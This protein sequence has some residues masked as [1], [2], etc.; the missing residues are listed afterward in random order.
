M[1]KSIK[2]ISLFWVLIMCFS[3]ILSSCNSDS[4]NGAKESDNKST[5]K[6]NTA[7]SLIEEGKYEEA[8][9]TLAELGDY[10]DAAKMLEKFRYVPIK[11]IKEETNG[12]L[13]NNTVIT[14]FYNEQ[15]LPKQLIFED[16]DGNRSIRDYIYNDKGN[17]IK[18]IYTNYSG[19]TEIVEYTYDNKENLIKKVHNDSD[20]GKD[21]YDYI[22][23][24]KGNLTKEVFNS[25]NQIIDYIYDYNG[26]LLKE[27]CTYS[28][29][30]KSIFDYT[31][32][33][34]GILIKVVSTDHSG[35]K[36]IYDYTY[37]NNG[38]LSK[39]VY[40]FHYGEKFTYNYTYD[41]KGNLIIKRFS[42]YSSGSTQI[43]EIEYRLAYVPFEL[44]TEE[45]EK[46]YLDIIG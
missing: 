44:S 4:N 19:N 12:S 26:N 11:A 10:K 14:C 16:A 7:V 13:K 3:I 29:G 24:D 8:Y 36:N 34:K 30:R 22:Y 43:I 45:Y 6:Y 25:S 32:N 9:E 40:T 39:T 5:E 21:I 35:N 17:I 2:T 27:V 38:N 41:N 37:D 15:N 18:E 1:K 31:Y 23:D 46:M 33:D 42:A 28:N 20:G